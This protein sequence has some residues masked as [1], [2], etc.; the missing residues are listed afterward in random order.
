MLIEVIWAS[1]INCHFNTLAHFLFSVRKI[2]R[3]LL[4]V[5]DENI[6]RGFTNERAG[7]VQGLLAHTHTLTQ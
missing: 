7:S 2:I 6:K 4:G 5:M 3:D 1:N